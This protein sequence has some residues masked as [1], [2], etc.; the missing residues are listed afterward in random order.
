MAKKDKE[1][2]KSG[3]KEKEKKEV[4]C[5]GDHAHGDLNAVKAEIP[6]LD[7]LFQLAELFKVFGDTTRIRIMCVLFQKELCVC[8]IAELLE[9]GQS[10][11]SH[12]LRLLRNAHLVKVKRDGKQSYYSLDDA[13]VREIYLMGLEHISE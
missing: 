9:M 13:H 4:L 12:Q 7:T 1:K 8:E 11:I 3:K 2:A 5:P 6:P 10:A